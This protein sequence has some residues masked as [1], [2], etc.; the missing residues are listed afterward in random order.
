MSQGLENVMLLIA[1]FV[2]PC[3]E[4][5]SK[6]YISHLTELNKSRI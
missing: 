2:L 6:H 3:L 5:C 4:D 1:N